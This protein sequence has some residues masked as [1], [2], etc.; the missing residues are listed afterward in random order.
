MITFINQKVQESGM[1]SSKQKHLANTPS[2]WSFYVRMSTEFHALM[3]PMK[4]IKIGI[5]QITRGSVGFEET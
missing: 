3:V 4:T 5:Q 1:I 2:Y